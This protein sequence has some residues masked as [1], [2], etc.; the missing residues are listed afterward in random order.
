MSV[1]VPKSLSPLVPE[2]IK[3]CLLRHLGTQALR[4]FQTLASII[5]LLQ[6][7]TPAQNISLGIDVLQKNNFSLL[8]G[9]RVG[10]ITN[11]TGV[12]SK[13]ESTL[14]LF[15]R[16]DN[17]KLTAVFSP[18]HGLKGLVASGQSFESYTDT[19]TRIKY[20][21]LYGKTAKPTKEMLEGIDALVY[22]IQDIGVRSYTYISTLGLAMEAAAENKIQFIVLDRPNPLGGLRIE[23]NIVED[24]FRSFVSNYAIPY[25]YGLTCGELAN[26]INTKAALGNKI[27]CKLKVVKME[28]WNRNMLFKDTGLIW[29]PTSPNVPYMETPSYLVASGVLG[30]L[31]VFGIGITYTLPFQTFAAEWIDADTIAVKMNALDLPGVLFRP[32]SYK[33]LYGDWKDQILNGVQIHITDFE[34]V[35]LLELQFYFLQVYHQLYPDTNPFTLATTNRMKMFD[36]VMGTDRV[37][38]KFSKRFRVDDIKKILHKDIDWFRKLSRRYYLYN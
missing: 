10:L 7:I 29:V 26:L 24:D 20:F 13:L 34:K 33:V 19:L 28:D 14:D 25:V 22:D 38:L 30:E 27:K 36:L 16:A 5:I 23:G 8:T 31:V 6:T 2:Q 21:A 3:N 15:K 37:R 11:H 12:N 35:N 32:I 17:F 4:S 9:K 18:E 1:L